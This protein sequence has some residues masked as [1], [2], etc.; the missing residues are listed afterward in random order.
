MT[1]QLNSISALAISVPYAQWQRRLS[2]ATRTWLDNALHAKAK[3]AFQT[4][5]AIGK[6][7]DLQEHN[8]DWKKGETSTHPPSSDIPRGLNYAGERLGEVKSPGADT[9]EHAPAV[10]TAL[11]KKLRTMGRAGRTRTTSER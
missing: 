6:T 10:V 2:S 7:A 8:N 3:E 1:G 9:S 5:D 11:Q 4:A